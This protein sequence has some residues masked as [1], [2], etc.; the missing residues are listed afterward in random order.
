MEITYLGHS[1]FKLKGKNGTVVCDPFQGSVGFE[2][3]SVSADIVTSSHDHPDHNAI[4]KVKGTARREKPFVINM[5]GEY[6]VGGISIFG[7]PTYHD[8][9]K[10]TERG[11]N[12]I[13]IIYMDHLRV[14]H[15]GDL[16]HELTDAQKSQIG[17]IDVL[18]LP[19]GGKFTID[20]ATAVKL[21]TELDP[22]YVIPMHYRTEE[23]DAEL[24][25]ELMPLKKFLDEYGVNK[26][27]VKSLDV[28][29][30]KMPEEAEVVVLQRS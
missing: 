26:E 27:P 22:F 12:T 19:V 3:S 16:G 29:A 5:P 1:C 7:V 8:K 13:Y 28:D 4:S 21:I 2:M 25:G 10:G 24:F 23:H 17:S 15:L 18:L 14:C 9:S 20:A 11:S 6:E 30:E